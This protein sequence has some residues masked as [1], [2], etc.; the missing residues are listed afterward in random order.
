MTGTK[1]EIHQVAKAY[2]VYYSVGPTDDDD[3]YLV[4]FHSHSPFP[5]PIPTHSLRILK[6]TMYVTHKLVG[7]DQMSD[8]MGMGKYY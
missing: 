1:E 2:R 7:G 3:D 6:Y 4:K 8:T 5:I